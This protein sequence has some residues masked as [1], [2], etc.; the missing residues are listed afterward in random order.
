MAADYRVTVK[1]RNN[2]ILKAI[3]E[4]GGQPGQKWCESVGLSYVRVN[5]LINMTTGPLRR[6]GELT[7]T[8]Q[9]LCEAV[10]KLPEDLWSNEQ[11]YPLEKNFSELEMSHDQ[12]LALMPNADGP[13]RLGFEIEDEERAR[14]LQQA[15]DTL[16]YREQE[17]IKARHYD[18]KTLEQVAREHGLTR[19]RIRQIEA[20]ALRKLRHPS[21]SE[22]IREATEDS[23]ET[24]VE[25]YRKERDIQPKPPTDWPSLRK[26]SGTKVWSARRG[27]FEAASQWGKVLQEDRA[28]IERHEKLV[29]EKSGRGVDI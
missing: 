5:D 15:L 2:R 11:L 22:A 25:R 13:R 7:H 12:L 1:V 16:T 21:R 17:V 3:E 4:A 18:D 29:A 14:V 27:N 20:R 19:E 23:G 10:D 9:R 24:V 26:Q 8:A 28:L 6:N